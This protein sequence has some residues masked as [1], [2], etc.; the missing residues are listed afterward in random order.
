VTPL[1]E[2]LLSAETTKALQDVV[3]LSQVRR[4]IGPC[5][6]QIGLE[7]PLQFWIRRQ[8]GSL[9]GDLSHPSRRP[10]NRLDQGRILDAR[11]ADP[12]ADRDKKKN[13]NDRCLFASHKKS[14]VEYSG[15]T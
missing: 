8:C 13:A 4:T 9:R 5:R 7:A 15:M 6:T 1:L 12:F 11:L 10:E 2:T 14:V 3:G